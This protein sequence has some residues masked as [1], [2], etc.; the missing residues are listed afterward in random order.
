MIVVLDGKANAEGLTVLLCIN[1][2]GELK[3]DL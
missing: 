1:V 3:L 2:N